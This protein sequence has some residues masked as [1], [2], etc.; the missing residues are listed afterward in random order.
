MDPSL[1]PSKVLELHITSILS[2]L[3]AVRAFHEPIEL[4][5]LQNLLS[6]P[7]NSP[8]LRGFGGISAVVTAAGIIEAGV[9]G[10]FVV[11]TEIRWSAGDH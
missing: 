7:S 10:A 1:V 3:M 9:G 11:R 6:A 4:F 2:G 8:L 5:P